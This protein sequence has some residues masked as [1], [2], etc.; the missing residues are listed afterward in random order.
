MTLANIA[1]NIKGIRITSG[2]TGRLP[3]TPSQLSGP[4]IAEI[5]VAAGR[6]VVSDMGNYL[7][8]RIRGSM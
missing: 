8:N 1:T 3:P 2:S 6:T 5:S 7:V 4:L